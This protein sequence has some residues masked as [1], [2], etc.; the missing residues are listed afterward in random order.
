MEEGSANDSDGEV[1]IIPETDADRR[2]TLL[3]SAQATDDLQKLNKKDWELLR[4]ELKSESSM[5]EST[6]KEH[7][8]LPRKMRSPVVIDGDVIKIFSDDE[9][10][11]GQEARCDVLQ[12]SRSALTI[13]NM[14]PSTSSSKGKG[15]EREEMVSITPSTFQAQKPLGR[16]KLVQSKL[17]FRKNQI[18]SGMSGLISDHDGDGR[19]GNMPSAKP[20]SIDKPTQKTTERSILWNCLVCTL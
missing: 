11:D 20:S 18:T 15:K 13:E 12:T 19:I 6:K 10:S 9:K 5:S 14:C 2:R 4:D 7:S 1:E 3:D 16:G 17:Y 8:S